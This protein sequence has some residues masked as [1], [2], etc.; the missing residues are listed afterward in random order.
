MSHAPGSFPAGDSL[1]DPVRDPRV[2]SPTERTRRALILML[3][4]LFVPGGAQVVAGSRTLGRAALRVTLTVWAVVLVGLLWWL[5]S[6]A[7]LI[8]LLARDAVL[9]VVALALGLLAVGWAVLWLDTLRLIRVPLLAPG[10]RKATSVTTVLALLLTS[11]PLLFGGWAAHTSRGALGGVFGDGPAVA[12]SEGRY[13]ILVMGG[14]AGDGREGLRPDSIHV[15]S[16]DARSGAVV[17]FSLPRNLQN[18]PF[19]E[20]SPLWDVYPDGFSCGDSCILNA[21]YTQVETQHPGLYPDAEDPGAEAMMDAAGGIL[22]LEISGYALMDMGGFQQLIDAMGGVD[23]V[24]GGY[25]VHRGVRPDGEWGNIWF[26][27]GTHH[28]DGE[29]A[30]AFARSRHWSTD[31]ARIR[32]QQCM[33][34][35]MLDQFTPATVLTRF[36]GL[37]DA[38]Q[39]IV[40]TNLPQS[41]LGTFVDLAERSRGQQMRRLTIG[42]PDFGD[43]ERQFTTFPDYGLV[44]ERVDA[45]I[46]DDAATARGTGEAGREAAGEAGREAAGEAGAS[47]LPLLTVLAVAAQ[48]AG[49]EV[50]EDDPDTWPAP[51]TRPDGEPYTAEDLMHAEDLGQEDLLNHA[52]STNGLCAPAP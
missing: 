3:L 32:R 39:Q 40:T 11:G 47:A 34:A 17:M 21:L 36:E 27:P 46:A 2:A 35:A 23:L 51:P 13:N 7:S 42:P 4:T 41:Q 5:V 19:T 43:T 24:T 10:A 52:S 29:D 45:M 44:H 9:L 33:Q 6:R 15:A 37:L 22:G 50:D 1:R 30:L 16:V 26:E 48:E 14:D 49:P 20:G 8:S 18:A 28:F 38:G 12:R 25:V 31:Y